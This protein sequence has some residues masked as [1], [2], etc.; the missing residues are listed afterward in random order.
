MNDPSTKSDAALVMMI[1]DIGIL[2]DARLRG[3]RRHATSD[4]SN[5]LT[6]LFYARYG[7]PS[8]NL[9]LLVM[10]EFERRYAH[11]HHMCSLVRLHVARVLSQHYGLDRGL[12][13]YVVRRAIYPLDQMEEAREDALAFALRRIT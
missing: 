12:V 10:H 1:E 5:V 9:K 11:Y 7:Y 2:V 3:Q 8:Y 6:S 13:Q 4:L